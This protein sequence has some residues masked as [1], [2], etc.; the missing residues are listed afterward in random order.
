ME[1]LSF[2]NCVYLQ[3]H[4]IFLN[5]ILEKREIKKN[6]RKIATSESVVI[7]IILNIDIWL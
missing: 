6:D 3:P 4:I 2:G 5:C 7:R 1:E